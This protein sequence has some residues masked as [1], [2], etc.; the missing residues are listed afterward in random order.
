MARTIYL[1][2][3]ATTQ[4]LPEVV[5]AVTRSMCDAYANPSSVHRMGQRARHDVELAR[6]KVATLLHVSPGEIRFTSGGTESIH[7]AI[8]GVLANTPDKRHVITSSVEHEAT[9]QLAKQL[10]SEGFNVECPG[11]DAIGRVDPAELQDCIRPDTALVSVIHANNE[12]GVLNDIHTIAEFCADRGVPLHVDGVQSA[13]KMPIHLGKSP[14]ALFSLSSHKIHG[15]KGV[16]VLF[17][18]K[19][20]RIKPLFVGGT[21]EFGLRAGTENV[22]GI[23]GLGVAVERTLRDQSATI[24]RIASLRDRLEK[25]VLQAHPDAMIIGAGGD[26][27][28]NT[29]N[30]AFANVPAEGMLILMSTDGVCASSGSA[31]SS[32]SVQPSHVL[33][34]MNVP[35]EFIA[36]A[37]R[38]SLSRFTTEQ[39]VDFVAERIPDY[40]QRLTVRSA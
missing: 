25:G 17:V 14:V 21:Q 8:R 4:P 28:C 1:D 20:T 6:E 38:F 11:V 22:T 29:A 27:V 13:G 2:N 31:C 19:R 36:G 16:G 10:S 39:D 26:R 18:R 15:P 24:H 40:V 7:L 9:R 30:I 33:Q 35:D 3:N 23:V 12:T 5:D 34:A 32:G 37:I